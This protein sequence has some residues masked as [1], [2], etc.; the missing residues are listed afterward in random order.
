[1]LE[2]QNKTKKNYAIKKN[3]TRQN[4]KKQKLGLKNYNQVEKMPPAGL[5]GRIPAS[6]AYNR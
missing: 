5:G 2:T 6:Y 3:K 4:N 1:M